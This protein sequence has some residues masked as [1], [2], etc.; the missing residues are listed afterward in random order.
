MNA[1]F[2]EF[3]HD[4]SFGESAQKETVPPG[5]IDTDTV[6]QRTPLLPR[7]CTWD[8]PLL[9]QAAVQYWPFGAELN[10]NVCPGTIWPQ[11]F[12]ILFLL[13]NFHLSPLFSCF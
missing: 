11:T 3:L 13:L 12:Q 10:Q 7:S 9:N 2:S 4:P 1:Y 8:H 5:K 6:S